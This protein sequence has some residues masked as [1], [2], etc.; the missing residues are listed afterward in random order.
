MRCALAHGAS[1][2]PRPTLI[3]SN[4]DRYVDHVFGEHEVGGTSMLYVS[5]I[6]F[7]ELG[8]PADL[9]PR[10]AEEAAKVMEALPAVIL[11][12]GALAAGTATY[13]HRR[14][15]ARYATAPR[16][17]SRRRPL[18]TSEREEL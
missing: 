8:F 3:A 17:L 10:P 14:S 11:G 18:L 13:T 9:P 15:A 16:R 2:W 12:M 4:P 7:A 5:D 1:F 6:P